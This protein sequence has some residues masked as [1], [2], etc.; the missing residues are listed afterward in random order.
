MSG[1]LLIGAEAHAAIAAAKPR[2]DIER[3]MCS[4]LSPEPLSA[5]L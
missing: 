2:M 5:Q 3:D 4:E 1:P